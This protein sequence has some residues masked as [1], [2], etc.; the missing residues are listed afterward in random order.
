MER[1]T[2]NVGHRGGLPSVRSKMV[3]GKFH[4]RPPSISVASPAPGVRPAIAALAAFARPA[5]SV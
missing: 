3:I 2:P 4:S 5:R 1:R